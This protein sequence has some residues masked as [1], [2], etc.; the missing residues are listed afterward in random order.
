MAMAMRMNGRF[1]SLQAVGLRALVVVLVAV[2][3][4][5]CKQ[6]NVV[7]RDASQDMPNLL[8]DGPDAVLGPDGAGGGLDTA[9]GVDTAP[10]LP[11]PNGQ[12]DDVSACGSLCLVCPPDPA[13]A[14]VAQCMSGL[15]S[16]KCDTGFHPCSGRC[17]SDTSPGSCGTSCV[18]CVPPVGGTSTCVDG[19]CGGTCPATKK[20]CS[21]NCIDNA[22]ACNDI[23]PTGTHACTGLCLP[24]TAA[25]SCGGRC[26]PCADPPSHGAGSCT[27][28]MCGVS[29]D[30]GYKNCPGTTLCVLLTGCC[31]SGDCTTGGTGTVGACTAANVC[32]Y[33]CNS[34]THK[35]CGTGCIPLAACCSSADCAGTGSPVCNLTTH[36][37]EKRPNGATCTT[38]GECIGGTCLTCYP[39][40]DGDTYGNKFMVQTGMFCG[41]C[42]AG[43]A[44][45]NLDCKDSDPSVNPDAAFQITMYTPDPADPTPDGWDW[46]CNDTDD[47]ENTGTVLVPNGCAAGAVCPTCTANPSHLVPANQTCG[48]FTGASACA[49]ACAPMAP[50][51]FSTGISTYQQK[52]R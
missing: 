52:C 1:E 51:C 27:N 25:A 32:S 18:A 21:G 42:P 10:D 16:L 28:A 12:H 11:C 39:D 7:P 33:V 13:G 15:C 48:G 29:C 38:Q 17:L 24:D 20:L 14:G 26:S 9:P 35:M 43:S 3:P 8:P 6:G 49:A 40:G 31:G 5:A 22:M 44:S 23:C 45:N 50:G 19:L 2:T 36:A 4:V 41:V 34:A 46:N 30:V 37:C 47:R